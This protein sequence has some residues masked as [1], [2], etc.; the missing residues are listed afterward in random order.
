[1]FPFDDVIMTAIFIDMEFGLNQA[2]SDSGLNMYTIVMYLAADS[3]MQ[4][5]KS[6]WIN[7][8]KTLNNAKL[9]YRKTDIPLLQ[10]V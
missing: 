1:M 8:Y 4:T 3:A 6:L 5:L 7:T 2:I 10:L 9:N